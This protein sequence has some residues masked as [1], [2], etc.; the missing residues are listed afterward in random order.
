MRPHYEV[1][2]KTSGIVSSILILSLTSFAGSSR[3]RTGVMPFYDTVA[4]NSNSNRSKEVL[5]DIISALAEY[6]FIDL[7]ERAETDKLLKE[8]ALGQSGLIDER[9]AAKAGRV[10][11]LQLMIT[12]TISRKRISARVIDIETQK[13]ITAASVE[14][15]G[16]RWLA[17]KLA[18]GIEVHLAREKL[19]S[20]RNES[21]EIDFKFWV[22]NSTGKK[23]EN[24]GTTKIGEKVVFNFS[25]NKNGYLTIVDIQPGGDVVIL[26][27]NDIHP[28][29]RVEA[30]RLY[31]IPSSNDTFEIT[32]TEPAGADTLVA[33]FTVNRVKWLDRD[34][35]TGS[36]FW[37]VRKKEKLALSRGFQVTATGLKKDLWESRVIHI[38]V[39]K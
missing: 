5:S 8:I 2:M 14:R 38:N 15:T 29:N 4:G 22:E 1:N 3:L 18:S 6:R 20:L 35:L 24:R 26:F 7:M 37:S 10:H 32:V 16:S 27:P 36:G 33:F 39:E 11:G 9:T 25:S 12:G 19:K 34:K 31:K 30:G 23:I 13:I 21:R 17:E 28:S